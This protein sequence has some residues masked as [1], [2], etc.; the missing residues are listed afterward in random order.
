MV[1]EVSFIA[2]SWLSF[3]PILAAPANR[4]L[5]SC[6][7]ELRK[8]NQYLQSQT[9]SLSSSQK[10]DHKRVQFA[11]PRFQVVSMVPLPLLV[12]RTTLAYQPA[13]YPH[14]DQ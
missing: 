7:Q 10:L 8:T 3:T 4:K 13:K 1:V 9:Q 14:M 11:Q 6:K 12:D 5:R 2:S